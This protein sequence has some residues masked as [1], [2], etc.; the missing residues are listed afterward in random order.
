MGVPKTRVLNDGGLSIDQTVIWQSCNSRVELFYGKIIR[1]S[2]GPVGG[3]SKDCSQILNRQLMTLIK[4]EEFES[5]EEVSHITE[6]F[7]SLSENLEC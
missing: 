6:P 2:S 3:K 7:F 4:K 1:N 5:I